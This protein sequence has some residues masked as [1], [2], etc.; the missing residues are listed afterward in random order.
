MNR[1]L[2]SRWAQTGTRRTRARSGW[3]CALL[4][5][6]TSVPRRRWPARRR[7]RRRRGRRASLQANAVWLRRCGVRARPAQ[8]RGI[9]GQKVGV[10]RHDGS[11]YR[12][13]TRVRSIACVDTEGLLPVPR[14]FWLP[15]PPRRILARGGPQHRFGVGRRWAMSR[16]SEAVQD[17]SQRAQGASWPC[18]AGA[19]AAPCRS[20]RRP[21]P[22]SECLVASCR[23]CR[24]PIE[25]PTTI[26]HSVPV[27]WAWS[28]V[29]STATSGSPSDRTSS[30]A[31]PTTPPCHFDIPMRGQQ[32]LPRRRSHRGPGRADRPRD[33]RPRHRH[34][35]S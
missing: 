20:R 5:E 31:T 19:R 9:I 32:S 18:R 30:S 27:A 14:C 29:A 3:R 15:C 11:A 2:S 6:I 22:R 26:A 7:H 12:A 13:G 10:G 23:A 4:A 28:C 16:G 24:P 17:A 1:P 35:G 34:A 33:G 8:L 25:S 21:R